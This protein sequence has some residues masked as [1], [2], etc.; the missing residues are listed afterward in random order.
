MPVDNKRTPSQVA[1]HSGRF[2]GEEHQQRRSEARKRKKRGSPI[3]KG[4]ARHPSIKSSRDFLHDVSCSEETL[5]G[6]MST[7]TRYP[8]C[9]ILVFFTNMR[10]HFKYYSCQVINSICVA[11]HLST[12]VGL[13]VK[14]TNKGEKAKRCEEEKMRGSPITKG[15]ARYA[16]IKSSRDFLH[17]V[18]CSQK[19]P[20]VG[21][22]STSTST[23]HA[24]VGVLHQHALTL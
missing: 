16:P 23:H 6:M 24:H 21:M 1:I 17:D 4:E 22:M 15:E 14:N 19:T 12:L 13:L 8:L 2:V 5:S 9:P 18:S 11:G 20:L 7:S 10:S 3:T